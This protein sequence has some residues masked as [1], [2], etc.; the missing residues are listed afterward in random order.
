MADHTPLFKPGQSF[1]AAGFTCA[2][3]ETGIRCEHDESGHG[4]VI[5]PDS[6]ERF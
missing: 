2:A 6:N 5:A 4:F 3:E 1:T